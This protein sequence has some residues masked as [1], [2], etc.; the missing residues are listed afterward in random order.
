MTTMKIKKER[1]KKREDLMIPFIRKSGYVKISEIQKHLVDSKIEVSRPAT[2]NQLNKMIAKGLLSKKKVILKGV[3][4]YYYKISKDL[5]VAEVKVIKE[6]SV[7]KKS[8]SKESGYKIVDGV[9]VEIGVELKKV[10]RLW[11]AT[12]NNFPPVFVF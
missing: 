2:V 11:P 4:I 12:C 1:M 10:L 8:Q 7:K 6:K 5:D 3:A 9:K